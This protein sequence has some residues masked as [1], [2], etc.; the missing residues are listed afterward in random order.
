VL[1]PLA[2][3]RRVVDGAIAVG[4]AGIAALVVRGSPALLPVLVLAAALALRRWSPGLALVL[5]W[6][7][8]VV[9]MA[10]G[11]GA[12]PLDVAVFAVLYCCAAYG[13]PRTRWLALASA[14]AG[15]AVAATF[16]ALQ[17]QSGLQDR[18]HVG[19]VVGVTA[20]ISLLLSWTVGLLVRTWTLA[21]RNRRNAEEADRRAAAEHERTRI[22][23]DMHDVVAHSL[24]V[25]IAQADGARL[26]RSVDPDAVEEALDSIGSTARA[27]LADVRVLLH[28]LR[29]PA[30]TGPQPTLDD[31]GALLERFRGSGLE[32][33]REEDGDPKPLPSPVQIAAYRVVQESLTNVLRH[34]RGPAVVRLS[35]APGGL[36][37]TVE[38]PLRTPDPPSRPGAGVTGMQERAFLVGGHLRAGREEGAWVVRG[39]LPAEQQVRA[40]AAERTSG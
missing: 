26:V 18:L 17:L 8:A 31:L 35:W 3:W 19:I 6:T 5:A 27:A 24:A 40:G 7:G 36:A 9:Q 13:R 16:E 34:G 25:V 14:G 2:A 20:L 39:W 11:L 4:F 15:A 23:R 37:V 29:S 32:V 12:A 30:E 33:V 28:Q 1:R 21:Q 10:V 38:N 22:A